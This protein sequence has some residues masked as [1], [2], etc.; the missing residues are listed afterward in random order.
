MRHPAALANPPQAMED[1]ALCA[2]VSATVDRHAGRGRITLEGTVWEAAESVLAA[3]AAATTAAQLATYQVLLMG[4]VVAA[5][6][7]CSQ[8]HIQSMPCMWCAY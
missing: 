8:Y 4:I 7:T 6:A 1:V 5:R 2:V 3:G